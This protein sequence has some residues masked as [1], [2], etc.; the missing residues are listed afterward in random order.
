[1]PRHR[2]CW[3]RRRT[4]EGVQ[5]VDHPMDDFVFPVR[6]AEL[7]FDASLHGR[8][9]EMV[10]AEVFL[11]GQCFQEVCQLG[12]TGKGGRIDKAVLRK[13]FVNGGAFGVIDGQAAGE[14]GVPDFFRAVIGEGG[15][16]RT[17]VEAVGTEEPKFASRPVRVTGVV[18]EVVDRG[19][20]CRPAAA[21]DVG[22]AAPV[23][24]DGG[25]LPGG[26]KADIAAMDH[27]GVGGG[28]FVNKEGGAEAGAAGKRGGGEGFGE[29]RGI[30]WDAKII[31]GV[32]MIRAKGVK[33]VPEDIAGK[34]VH[35]NQIPGGGNRGRRGGVV[36]GL[37][38]PYEAGF[39]QQAA[40]ETKTPACGCL[41]KKNIGAEG[42]ADEGD[43]V[44]GESVL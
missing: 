25:V 26:M 8:E 42:G 36:G 3:M 1:M 40:V 29:L 7:L 41:G 5:G 44:G 37:V 24:F 16:L 22:M 28:I 35:D 17:K 12:R 30:Q 32:E 19:D 6:V 31:G 20:V 27:A 23:E 34:G 43:P 10:A 9:A 21:D 33:V 18:T 11:H 14:D 13:G 4:V 39:A 38:G 15:V 2:R